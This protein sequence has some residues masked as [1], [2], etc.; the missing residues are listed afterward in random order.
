[1]TTVTNK[2][3]E[4]HVI[5]GAGPV[6]LAIMEALAA[7]GKRVRIINRT[8]LPALPDGA[9]SLRGDMAGLDFARQ[10]AAGAT[11]IYDALNAPYAEWADLFPPLQKS[12]LE[13]AAAAGARLIALENLYMY[14]DMHGQPMTEDLPN[15][16]TTVKGKVRAQMSEELLAAHQS[17][18]VR[19]AIVRAADFVGPRAVEG[20]LGGRVFYPA[21][22]GKAA[23]VLGNP[24][25]PH[26]YSYVPDVAQAMITVGQADCALGQIWHVPNAAT[27]TTAGYIGQIFAAIGQPAKIAAAPKP[28]LWLL[29]RFN[30]T[31][32]AVYEMTYQFEQPFILDHSKFVAAFGNM[33]TPVPAVVTETL[34]WYR[35]HPQR[36]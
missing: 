28:A 8:G 33:A 23:S 29:G 9:E 7:R 21:L 2:A 18:R 31:I 5:L 10:A 15:A 26:T 12:V 30:P 22:A 4:L 13:A 3:N 36:R 19:V 17:G 34:A 6:G 11:H 20:G 14:G 35:S 25:M 16:A 24:N 27:I 1:M 32:A